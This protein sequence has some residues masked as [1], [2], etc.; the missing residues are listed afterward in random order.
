MSKSEVVRKNVKTKSLKEKTRN[1]TEHLFEQNQ[2]EK[3]LLSRN[4]KKD[5]RRI[6]D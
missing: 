2:N 5:N 3:K 4:E 6:S 1:N